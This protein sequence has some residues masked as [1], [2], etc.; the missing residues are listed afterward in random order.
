MTQS[1]KCHTLTFFLT[2]LFQY[3]TS[4]KINK[5]DKISNLAQLETLSYFLSGLNGDEGLQVLS[6]IV[7]FIPSLTFERIMSQR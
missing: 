3:E 5:N 4:V 6:V 2:D 1:N 7:L